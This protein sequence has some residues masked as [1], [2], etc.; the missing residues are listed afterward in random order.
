[1]TVRGKYSIL[2]DVAFISIVV[3]AI[4]CSGEIGAARSRYFNSNSTAETS[5]T[6]T[7]C[8]A[9]SCRSGLPVTG[10][11]NSEAKRPRPLRRRIPGRRVSPKLKLEALQEIHRAI[12]MMK[13]LK[14]LGL[15]RKPNITRTRI[16]SVT[17]DKAVSKLKMKAHRPGK[18]GDRQPYAH[19]S[20]MVSFSQDDETGNANVIQFHLGEEESKRQDILVTHANVWVFIKYRKNGTRKNP[21]RDIKLLIYDVNNNG[22]LGGAVF[23]RDVTVRHSRWHR[24]TLPK[25]MAQRMFKNVDHTLRLAVICEGC[26]NG[27]RPLLARRRRFRSKGGTRRQR[28]RIARIARYRKLHSSFSGSRMTNTKQIRRLNRR[29]PFLVMRTKLKPSDRRKRRSLTCDGRNRNCCKH[30]FFVDFRDL[31][32]DDWIIAP[33][34]YNADFCTGKCDGF[35][36]YNLFSTSHS[37]VMSGYLYKKGHRPFDSCCTPREMAPISLLH[38]DEEGNIVK[39]DLTDMKVVS[40]GCV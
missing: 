18:H 31:N 30:S 37:T 3:L 5:G 7:N 21:L 17:F 39:T 28:A 24:L 33:H 20:E 1:M 25:N 27:I 32:W 4:T 6:N 38:F 16:P 10:S 12:N 22:T 15:S 9:K 35:T 2:L 8:T 26:G 29:R 13:I 36:P 40:C 34:G 19:I 14:K 11:G 23:G